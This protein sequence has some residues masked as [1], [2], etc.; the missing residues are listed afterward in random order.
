MIHILDSIRN[1]TTDQL[2]ESFALD[3][4]MGFSSKNKWV[5]SKYFY[6]TKG[7]ELF[8]AIMNLESYYPS[9]CEREIFETHKSELGNI[10]ENERF[11]IIELGAGDGRKTKVLLEEFTSKKLDFSYLPIDISESAVKDLVSSLDK[12]FPEL[13][14]TGIVGEYMPGVEF[15]RAQTKGRNL[16]LFLGSNIGNFSHTGSLVFLRRLWKGLENGDLVLI[17]FDLKKHVRTL[18][19]AYNDPENVTEEFNL[20]LL[21]RINRELGGH[22]DRSKFEHLG[23]YNPNIGAMESYLVSLEEQNIY[24]D[25]IEKSFHFKAF[26]PI[27]LEYSNKFLTHEIESLAQETGYEVV[28]HFS[29]S[30]KYFVDSLWRVKKGSHGPV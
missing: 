1:Q 14:K 4:L 25:E 7:S 3:I 8:S 6:D 12:E 24:I 27:H 15:S 10:L 29:D 17:G 16:V 13:E 9:R 18:T 28:E 26:E 11:N 23:V 22:F 30:R 20:N 5:P 19:N 21:D 2:R